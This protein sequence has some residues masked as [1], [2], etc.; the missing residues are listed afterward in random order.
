M[1]I[2]MNYLTL[3]GEEGALV[4]Q[5]NLHPQLAQA[6]IEFGALQSVSINWGDQSAGFQKIEWTWT[7]GGANRSEPSADM[8]KQLEVLTGQLR[9]Y[10]APEGRILIGLSKQDALIDF[11]R[12]AGVPTSMVQLNG[13]GRSITG[14]AGPITFGALTGAT[15]AGG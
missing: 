5:N 14:W 1:P 6:G 2:F 11:C 4:C 13:D 3:K 10:M 7:K 8:L 9:A 12:A 15:R